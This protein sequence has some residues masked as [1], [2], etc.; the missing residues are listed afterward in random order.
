ML[1]NMEKINL[2][3]I[4][5]VDLLYKANGEYVYDIEVDDDTHTFFANNILVHNSLYIGYQ[6]LIDS[7]EGSET[8]TDEQKTK[9]IVEVNTKFLDKHNEEFMRD[10]YKTRHA[11]S[12]HNFELETCAKSGIWLNVKKRYAQLLTYKDGKYFD[13]GEL[14]IKT[15]GLEVVKS[16]YP[17]MARNA[18]KHLIRFLLENAGDPYLQQKM[19]IEVQKCKD[20]FYKADI[21]SICGSVGVSGYTKYVADDKGYVLKTNPKC[22]YNCKA[23]GNYNWMRNHY[24]L[25]GEPIYGGKVKWY[26][27]RQPGAKD[28][29]YFAFQSQNY[30]EWA[31]K[32]APINRQAMFKKTVLD[33]LN[34]VINITG[35]SDILVD[36]SIQTS[37]F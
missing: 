20:E 27:F 35:M 29:D 15:R 22:P 34:R 10:Y 2:I 23:L 8:W 4:D 21:E 14:P 12:V 32:Y 33:P 17:A 13:S 9:F 25:P 24:G 6:G 30:P 3:E 36:G 7:I 28:D 18:L 16:S 26:V 1:K 31:Y 37:L 5:S 19:N 11:E